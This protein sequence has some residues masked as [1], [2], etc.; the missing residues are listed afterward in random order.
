MGPTKRPL[1]LVFKICYFD[2]F[3]AIPQLLG[4]F[5]AWSNI[6]SAM[7]ALTCRNILP[8]IL[9]VHT[10]IPAHMSPAVFA[11]IYRIHGL[12]NNLFDDRGQLGRGEAMPE[13]LHVFAASRSE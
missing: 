6:K 1:K 8:I 4:G 12:S 3:S 9:P 7:S 2:D 11:L 5:F 10:G 13:E